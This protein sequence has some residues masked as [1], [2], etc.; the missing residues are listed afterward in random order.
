MNVFRHTL[1]VAV[2]AAT[3]A[4]AGAVPDEFLRVSPGEVHWQD[5]PGGHGAQAATLSGDPSRPGLYVIRVRFPP[6]VMSMPHTHPNARY[7]TVLEG[8]WYTGTGTKFDVTRAVALPPGSFMLHPA[9][10]P[11][12]DGS[13]GDA[14]V[15]V[16]II[17]E[18]P[19]T[20]IPIDPH[21][22]EWTTARR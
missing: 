8:T 22:P 13:A 15:V 6:H 3:A 10:A 21:A 2:L 5:I 19:A 20:S 14:P 7:A 16:Q 9:G 4:L 1:L 11:H 17:G 12:W 18:G